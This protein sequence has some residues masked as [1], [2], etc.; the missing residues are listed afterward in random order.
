MRVRTCGFGI[1]E[2][3]A[4]AGE[5][6]A[7]G[8]VRRELD[9][10]IA[11]K[12]TRPSPTKSAVGS[13]HTQFVDHDRGHHPVSVAGGAEAYSGHPSPAKSHAAYG[14]SYGEMSAGMYQAAHAGVVRV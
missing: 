4:L 1:T 12:S 13:S 11:L 6:F 10:Q 9:E 14:Q 8:L 2:L 5:V 3:T 7:D